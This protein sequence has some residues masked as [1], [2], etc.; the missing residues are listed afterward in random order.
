MRQMTGQVTDITT[1]L[2]RLVSGMRRT[3][4]ISQEVLAQQLHIDKSLLARIEIGRNMATID[5]V[6]KLEAEFMAVKML[7]DHGDLV[8]LTARAASAL[9]RRGVRVVYGKAVE[10]EGAPLVELA[11][12][13][14]LISGVLDRWW[15][16]LES[17]ST[18]G[19]NTSSSDDAG[20]EE[21]E[22]GEEGG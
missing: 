11:S 4:G 18:K 9:K 20:D 8:E 1:V 6:M 7:E 21:D 3:M 5:N 10:V 22:Y 17:V 12:L 14:R 19:G 16:D 15:D 2:G 13:D